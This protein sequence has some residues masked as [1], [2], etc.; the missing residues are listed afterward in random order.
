M[1]DHSTLRSSV[2]L[3]AVAALAGLA[4]LAASAFAVY[5][6]MNEKRL[7]STPDLMRTAREPRALP[8]LAF[9]DAQGKPVSLSD[10]RGK[11]VLLNVWATWCTPCRAEMPALDRVQQTLGGPGFE[12]VALSIDRGGPTAVRPFYNEIGIRTL[13]I[14]V[15]PS[16]QAAT[17]L[18]TIGIPTT[19][20]VDREGRELWRKTGPAEWD[21]PKYLDTLRGHIGA[22]ASASDSR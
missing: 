20:L 12:V 17:K 18:K 2:W 7:P 21:G 9:Q 14:Y 3:R 13:A 19:L 4:V 22:A 5:L 16:T 8:E 10:F 15:D 1:N 11:V 6:Y